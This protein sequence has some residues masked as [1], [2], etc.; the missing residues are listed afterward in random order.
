[1]LDLKY[2][3]LYL[4]A[5]RSVSMQMWVIFLGIKVGHRVQGRIWH[6]CNEKLN[7]I[8]NVRTR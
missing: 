6:Y 5:R 8:G 7:K 1:M 3:A 2:N 4:F